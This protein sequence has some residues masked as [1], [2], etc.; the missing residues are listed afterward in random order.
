MYYEGKKGVQQDYAEAIEWFQKA[1]EQNY[2]LDLMIRATFKFGEMYY[3]G[4]GVPRNYTEAMTLY[5]IAAEQNDDIGLMIDARFKLGERYYKGEGV[6]R[7]Y[8]QAYMWLAL[9]LKRSRFDM[10]ATN[11]SDELALKMTPSQIAEALKLSNE[12]TESHAG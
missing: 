2:D 4:E 1:A 6:P 9:I 7:D 3:K 10:K 11:L 8:V 5:C 12:W